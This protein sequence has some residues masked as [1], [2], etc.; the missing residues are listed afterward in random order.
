[1]PSTEANPGDKDDVPGK[2][3][4]GGCSKSN[5]K[6]PAEAREVRLPLKS[7]VINGAND[8]GETKREEEVPGEAREDRH[9]RKACDHW[10]L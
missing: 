8:R 2:A 10:S 4:E 7:C 1:M 3:C 9:P 5:E 6:V